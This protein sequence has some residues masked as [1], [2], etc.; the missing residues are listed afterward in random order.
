MLHKPVAAGDQGSTCSCVQTVVVGTHRATL[1]FGL[2]V[3]MAWPVYLRQGRRSSPSHNFL[4]ERSCGCICQS[5]CLAQHVCCRLQN[6]TVSLRGDCQLSAQAVN[7]CVGSQGALLVI[8]S[9]GSCL[10]KEASE[11]DRCCRRPVKVVA[12]GTAVGSS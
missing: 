11:I 8:S 9:A 5:Q 7:R 2:A 4:S 3:Q 12:G 6:C 10:Q 1:S